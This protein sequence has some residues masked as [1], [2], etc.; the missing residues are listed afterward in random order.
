MEREEGERDAP[1]FPARAPTVAKAPS[2]PS[3]TPSAL[4][5]RAPKSHARAL[6]RRPGVAPGRR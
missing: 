3:P 1:F 2:T 6:L 4:S 5:P